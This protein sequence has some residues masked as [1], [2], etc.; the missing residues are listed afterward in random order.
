MI[1]I[2]FFDI[3]GTLLPLRTK[4]LTPSLTKALQRLQKKKEFA[5][6]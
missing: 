6:F 1:K 5:Y 2:I 3:D 4:T